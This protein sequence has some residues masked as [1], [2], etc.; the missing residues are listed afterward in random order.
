MVQTK[1]NDV[2]CK[3]PSEKIL[4]EISAVFNGNEGS[5]PEGRKISDA[6]CLKYCPALSVDVERSFSLYKTVLTD[7]RHS[8]TEENL[9][10][11]MDCNYF[12][13]RE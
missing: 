3:N 5:L 9:C 2:F 11:I 13:S 7:R 8:L 10:K 12:Y 1:V 4:R 6:A